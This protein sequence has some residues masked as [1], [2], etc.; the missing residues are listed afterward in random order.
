MDFTAI[1][2]DVQ[3]TNENRRSSRA[4]YKKDWYTQVLDFLSNLLALLLNLIASVKPIPSIT[5]GSKRFNILKQVGEGGFSFVF[6]V[7]EKGQYEKYCLKQIKIQLP[8]HE[9]RLRKE[10]ASH[11]LVS[12]PHVLKLLDST[13]V[14]EHGKVVQGL[15]LLPWFPNGTIQDLINRTPSDDPIPLKVMMKLMTGICKGLEAFHTRNPPLA[16]RDLKPANILIDPKGNAVLMDLG[17]VSE[18]VVL[19]GRKHALAFKEHCEETVT[20]PYRAP[21]LF[22]PPSVGTIDESCDL[23]ALG[24]V[25]YAM[26]YRSSPFDGSMTATMSG[27]ILFPRQSFY[28]IQL[29]EF[30]ESILKVNP[31]ERPTLEQI[32]HQCE[33]WM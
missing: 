10:I 27:S 15:L 22:D 30:I 25:L 17:S 21:E 2:V 32:R 1:D 31:K 4:R 18:R 8:E 19:A 9:E 33:L 6:L 5:L 26:A 20:A 7:V 12:S 14:K 29:N 11:G 16:F 23:W 3:E 28:P 24:C 13:L